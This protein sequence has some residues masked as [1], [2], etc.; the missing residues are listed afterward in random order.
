MEIK[1]L[2]VRYVSHEIRTPMNTT[3]LGLNLLQTDLKE[4]VL[5]PTVLSEVVSDSTGSCT[6]AIGILNDLLLYEKIDGGLLT[7]E[8]EEMSMWSFVEDTLKVFL[9]QVSLTIFL[10]FYIWCIVA[11]MITA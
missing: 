8:K 10:L 11:S 9:I 1:R 2:F 5:D 6:I 3:L 7:L 4:G